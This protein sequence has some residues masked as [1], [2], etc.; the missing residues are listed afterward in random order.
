MD[1][2]ILGWTLEMWIAGDQMG[3]YPVIL[4]LSACLAGAVTCLEL[5]PNQRGLPLADYHYILSCVASIK[6]WYALLTKQK[7]HNKIFILLKSK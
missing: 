6:E 2:E 1:A 5:A 4:G 7:V 3:W